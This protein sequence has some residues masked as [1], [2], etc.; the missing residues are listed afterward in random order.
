MFKSMRDLSCSHHGPLQVMTDYLQ[1]GTMADSELDAA[2]RYF[3]SLTDAWIGSL[4]A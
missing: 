1:T 3:G 2:K 4:R